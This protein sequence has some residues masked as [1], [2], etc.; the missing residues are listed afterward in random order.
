M[1]LDSLSCILCCSNDSSSSGCPAV[2]ENGSRQLPV[3]TVI[4]PESLST[5]TAICLCLAQ[6]DSLTKICCQEGGSA[7]QKLPGENPI[8]INE[9]LP[10]VIVNTTL[11]IDAA[12]G[13]EHKAAPLTRTE[14]M[15]SLELL[16]PVLLSL[17]HGF[18]WLKI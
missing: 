13:C 5:T 9:R 2:S 10:L 3:I 8:L 4:F 15:D 16:Q 1:P 14:F 7:N 17:G 18:Y 12:I 6:Q 11:M